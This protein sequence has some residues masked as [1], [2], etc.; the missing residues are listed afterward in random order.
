MSWNHQTQ[1]SRGLG[2]EA[3]ADDHV[4]GTVGRRQVVGRELR[5]SL[6]S[7]EPSRKEVKVSTEKRHLSF[8]TGQAVHPQVANHCSGGVMSWFQRP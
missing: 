1:Q 4:W 3:W 5:G 8:A 2:G 6:V 7:G